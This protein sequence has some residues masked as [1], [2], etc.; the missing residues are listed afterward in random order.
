MDR[1][2]DASLLSH[3][4]KCVGHADVAETASPF[5]EVGRFNSCKC[6]VESRF[7]PW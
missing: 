6:A 1:K 2:V 7:I 5:G 4:H 3:A